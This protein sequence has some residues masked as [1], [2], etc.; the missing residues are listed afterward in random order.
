MAI[1]S[2]AIGLF[3]VVLIL[4]GLRA[5]RKRFVYTDVG[6]YQ[7]G[8]AIRWGVI[9]IILG[10]LFILTAVFDIQWFKSA[11]HFFFNG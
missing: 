1:P 6:E 2:W 7:G 11:V 4:S 8:S 5:I 9:W 3:G 10:G